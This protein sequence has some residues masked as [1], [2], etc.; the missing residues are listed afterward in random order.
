MVAAKN[1]VAM[2]MMA[3]D[4][5][6]IRRMHI[7]GPRARAHVDAGGH[8]GRGVDQRGDGR[9]AGHGVG[10]PGVERNLRRFAGRA[11]QQQQADQRQRGLRSARRLMEHRAEIERA[12]LLED[13]EHR[14]R[15]SEIADAVDDER[16]V[17]GVGGELFIE[18]EAD[19]QVAAQ[20]HAFP[21]D[22]EN[23][24]V[25]RQH[26]GQHEEHEQVQIGE[27]AV[28]AAKI[29]AMLVRHV[30]DGIDVDQ[31]ADAGDD[32]QHDGA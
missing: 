7:D 29:R 25:R 17:A 28:I 10:Q 1:A 13:E 31:G 19:Q 32:Q 30:A 11:H 20:A 3:I 14:Q 5:H 26:Q 9:G 24:V 27:E 6:R 16:L 18:V 8:H 15:E 12:E 4:V 21:A 2:P 22:E 23:Q